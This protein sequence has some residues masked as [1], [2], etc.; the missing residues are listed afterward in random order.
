MDRQP[1]QKNKYGQY[2]YNIDID[3]F[4]I[5]YQMRYRN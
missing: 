4:I 3:L 5:Y 1:A 2:S